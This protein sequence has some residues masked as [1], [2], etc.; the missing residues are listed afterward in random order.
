MRAGQVTIFVGA[1]FVGGML[2]TVA[3]NLGP[4]SANAAGGSGRAVLTLQMAADGITQCVGG[5][6]YGDEPYTDQGDCCPD[7]FSTAGFLATNAG[8]NA[9]AEDAIVVCLE[10]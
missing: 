9:S 7:G 4:D 1:G 5:A 10:D 8:N 3:C 2:W 6:G